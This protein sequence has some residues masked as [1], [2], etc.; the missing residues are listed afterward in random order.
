MARA[1]TCL[2]ALALHGNGK[3]V[4]RAVEPEGKVVENDGK[5]VR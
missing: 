2:Q 5:E 4:L 3:L 1:S